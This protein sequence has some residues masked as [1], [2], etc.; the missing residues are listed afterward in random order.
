[1]PVP[2]VAVAH[3]SPS[4]PLILFF[5]L[6][7][8]A[9]WSMPSLAGDFAQFSESTGERRLARIQFHT[10]DELSAALQRSAE[11]FESGNWRDQVDSPV[12]FILHGPEG[13]ALLRARYRQHKELVD[14]AA[15]LAALAVVDI[16]VC[17]TWMGGEGIR[18]E[19][20]QPF[21]GTV[22]F[23]PEAERQLR[24]EQGYQYF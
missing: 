14:L 11:L 12:V 16:R 10:A 7:S 20:L 2:P 4:D 1:M 17:E 19:E 9:V 6:L 23:G 8:I 24:D 15:R 5:W 3:R 18:A 13:K 22:P 21:V